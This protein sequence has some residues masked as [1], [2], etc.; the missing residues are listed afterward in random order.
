M[1]RTGSFIRGES[2]IY[3]LDPRLKLAVTVLLSLLIFQVEQPLVFASGIGLF[4][5]A[6]A[7]GIR[8]RTIG[9]SIRPVLFFIV[10]IFLSHLL[11]SDDKRSMMTIPFLGIAFSSAGLKQGTLVVGQFLCLIVGAVLLTMTTAPSQ[12]I[13][14]L[15]YFL[16][17]FKKL[18]LP[19][20]DVA[21]MVALAL[22]LM[23]LL[24]M[25]KERIDAARKARGFCLR[26][27]SVAGRMNSFLSLISKMLLGI[28]R[29]ADDIALAME[30]RNYR[31]GGRSSFV[32]L[33]FS[34]ADYVVLVF[35]AIF[36]VI[37][38]AL[39]SHF[40]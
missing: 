22:R 3:R 36:L 39:N 2:F 6:M 30:A 19:V 13:A 20:D 4:L 14:A 21:V 29:K 37:F 5:L 10:L 16:K 9:E 8:L 34:S 17:P 25:E 11:F 23:P 28:F 7:S 26:R 35:L 15:R 18:R 38:V 24:L 1:Y 40:G 27:Q 31:R 12:I 33:K 32:E